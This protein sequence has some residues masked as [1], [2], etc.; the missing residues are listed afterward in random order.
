MV[1]LIIWGHPVFGDSTRTLFYTAHGD[2]NK[3]LYDE[4][5]IKVGIT[6]S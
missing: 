3:K 5:Y 6:S 1:V 2:Y 4:F